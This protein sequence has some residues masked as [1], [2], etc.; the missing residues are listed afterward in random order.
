MAGYSSQAIDAEKLARDR[1]AQGVA[2]ERQKQRDWAAG[3]WQWIQ[4]AANPHG[5]TNPLAQWGAPKSVGQLRTLIQQL[6]PAV[7]IE[8]SPR[9]PEFWGL[10]VVQPDQSRKLL[11]PAGPYAG[12]IIPEYSVMEEATVELPYVTQKFNRGDPAT[13]KERTLGKESIRGWRTILVRLVERGLASPAAVEKLVGPSP[14]ASWAALMKKRT[15]A[16][17]YF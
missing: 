2:A 15:D 8:P 11:F 10:W 17:L 4:C 14:R 5:V 12:G 6:N 1:R 9:E 3:Q 7:L 13:L 16:P